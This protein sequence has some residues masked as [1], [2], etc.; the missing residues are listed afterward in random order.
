MSRGRRQGGNL[1]GRRRGRTS[2]GYRRVRRSRGGRREYSAATRSEEQRVASPRIV[3]AN[4]G[5]NS[6]LRWV[7][8][9]RRNREEIEKKESPKKNESDCWDPTTIISADLKQ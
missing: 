9:M 7:K 2:G 5:R 6:R 8:M 1:G 4:N 3:Q